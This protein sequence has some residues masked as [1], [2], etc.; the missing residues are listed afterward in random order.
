MSDTDFD[1]Y[2][3]VN[4]TSCSVHIFAYLY[5]IVFNCFLCDVLL[6][7]NHR[8]KEL[9]RNRLIECGWRDELKQYCKGWFND[10]DDMGPNILHGVVSVFILTSKQPLPLPQPTSVVHYRLDYCNSLYSQLQF[11]ARQLSARFS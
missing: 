7:Y 2:V 8:L 6:M 5:L 11:S 10:D 4:H 9:L 1:Y 3:A